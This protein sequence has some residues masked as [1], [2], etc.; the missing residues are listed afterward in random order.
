M[1]LRAQFDEQSNIQ[2]VERLRE[3]GVDVAFQLPGLKVH[4]KLLL[5]E[6]REEGEPRFYAYLSTGNFNERTARVYADAALFTA[7]GGI[8]GDVHRLFHYLT[9]RKET[10]ETEYL[11]VA[12]LSLRAGVENLIRYEME[13]AISPSTGAIKASVKR[14]AVMNRIFLSSFLPENGLSINQPRSKHNT[15]YALGDRSSGIIHA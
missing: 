1:E 5:L 3:R 9:G 2:W 14:T 11:M 6:R 12:P 13:E 7:H 4:A 8:A 10:L 15:S